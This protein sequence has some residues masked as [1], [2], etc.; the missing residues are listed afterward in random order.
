MCILC[1]RF[2]PADGVRPQG[3]W[4]HDTDALTVECAVCGRYPVSR[5]MVEDNP[6]GFPE[7]IGRKLSAVT[8]AAERE[9][10]TVPI[11]AH[12]NYKHLAA[13]GLGAE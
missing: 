5:E 9:K 7:D 13:Y 12:E 11:I 10:R 2:R 8:L 6:G 4:N 1:E 3:T